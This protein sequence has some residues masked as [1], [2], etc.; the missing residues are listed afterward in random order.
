V[1]TGIV[2]AGGR[3]ARFGADKLTAQLE[4]L[5]LVSATISRFV[6][7]VDG[8]IVAGS[9]PSDWR[10]VWDDS[11][12]LAIIPDADPF[13]GP[14]A[15]LANVLRPASPDQEDLAIV[16]GGDMPAL[17]PDVLRAMFDRLERG[18]S[19]D[20]LVLG[21]AEPLSEPVAPLQVLPLALRVASARTVV[22]DALGAGR[23]S[24]RSLLDDLAWAAIPGAEWLPLDPSASTLLDVDT[25]EDLDRLRAG[26]GR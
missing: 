18:P 20:A 25:P 7:I 17:V 3:S 14:L 24:L 6:G 12:P 4:G 10:R 2:L 16:V 19:V 5:S 9:E 26:K 23:H 21:A 11:V 15:A 13:G 1:R 8:L 22:L